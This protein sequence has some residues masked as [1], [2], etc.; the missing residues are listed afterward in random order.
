MWFCWRVEGKGCTDGDTT[1]RSWRQEKVQIRSNCCECCATGPGVLDEVCMEPG[2]ILA[3]QLWD[4]RV[5]A[6][7]DADHELRAKQ[8]EE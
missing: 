2:G 1:R 3:R 5:P 6:P 4:E 8:E 7:G